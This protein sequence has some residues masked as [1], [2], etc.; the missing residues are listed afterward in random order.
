MGRR[1]PPVPLIGS[2]KLFKRFLFAETRAVITKIAGQT[3]LHAAK[4]FLKLGI[5]RVD[6]APPPG[7]DFRACCC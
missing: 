2:G 6:K 1:I 5:E 7:A 3:S 4:G